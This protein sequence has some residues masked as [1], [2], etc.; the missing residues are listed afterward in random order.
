MVFKGNWAF[1]TGPAGLTVLDISVPTAP[2][3]AA[4]HPLPHFEN[5]DVDLWTRKR[6]LARSPSPPSYRSAL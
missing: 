1:V 5:E 6:H 4:V 3:V 2:T